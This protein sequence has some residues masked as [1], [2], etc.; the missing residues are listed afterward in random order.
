MTGD[1]DALRRHVAELEARQAGFEQTAKVQDALYRIAE[2]ASAVEDLPEFYATVH[3]IVAGLMYADNAYIALYD[4]QR[5]AINYPYYVDSVDTDLP[6]PNLWE[7][8]G[9]GQATGMT[10]YALR[11]GKPLLVDQT[12]YDDLVARGEIK[13]LGALGLGWLGAPLVADGRTLGVIVVQTY[14]ADERYTEADRDLLA[15]V[16]QHIGT[17]L[18]RVRAIEETRQRNAELALVNEIGLALGKQLE[19]GA[20]IELVGERLRA[21]FDVKSMFIATYDDATELISFRYEIETG[22]ALPHG[23]VPA[24]AGPDVDRHPDASAIALGARR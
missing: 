8:M 12:A 6:D 22:Q 20:I 2:A 13:T 1:I 18:S 11:L 21:L 3:R 15:F 16:G 19:F 5:Q 4:D 17:A 24:R 23:G 10:A 7:S 9:V 14:T